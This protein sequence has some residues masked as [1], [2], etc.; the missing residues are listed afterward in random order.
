MRKI[1]AK[2]ISETVDKLVIKA[3]MSLRPDVLKALKTALSQEKTNAARNALSAIIKN[4]S[5]AK[6]EKLAICQDTGIPIIFVEIGN[7]VVVG[8][9]ISDIIN[10]AIAKSYSKA[11]L[12][13]SIQADPV[14]RSKKPSY[15]PGI[16]HTDIVAGDKM[17]ITILPKGFGSE[18][19]ARVKML[20][21]TASIKQIEDF[22]VDSVRIAGANACPPYII[23]VGIGGT[24]DLAGLLAKKA[25]L[26]S[27]AKGN[28][29]KKI[30]LLEKGILEKIN[31]LK[32]GP[33]GLGGK[34]TA[35]AV[36]IQTY[37]THIAGLPIAVNI[38]CHAL[39]SASEIL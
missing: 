27:I 35:L 18:N 36:N 1:S 5:I 20:N 26:R 8:G 14:F 7:R 22:I 4:A 16:V 9:N 19:K 24:Q 33:F 17:R 31:A 39:R 25:L 15:T 10:V 29:D 23:G 32:I 11:Y 12:R 13:A 3:N 6:K 34:N 2:L 38:S 28:R 37:P 30:A 21:P